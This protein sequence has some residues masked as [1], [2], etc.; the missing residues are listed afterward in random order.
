MGRDFRHALDPPDFI[1][2]L[3]HQAVVF[4]GDHIPV[5]ER[6]G[7]QPGEQI[8]VLL[9][10]HKVRQRFLP[11]DKAGVMDVGN[12]IDLG[13]DAFGLGLGISLVDVNQHLVVLFQIQ[14]HFI[15]VVENQAKGAH[16]QQTGHRD[17]DGREGHEAV[18]KHATDA[19]PQQITDIILLHTRNTHPFRR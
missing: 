4:H 1:A 12:H 10:L 3:L 18:E 15:E 13:A 19:L 11:G 6:G 5:P 7:L 2:G 8:L 14:D 17:P 16:N 9:L